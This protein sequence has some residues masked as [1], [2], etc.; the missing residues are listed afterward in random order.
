MYNHIRSPV[1]DLL[2][3]LVVFIPRPVPVSKCQ[4]LVKILD[5]V[6]C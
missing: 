5:R 4:P 3:Y 1:T 6:F 2:E